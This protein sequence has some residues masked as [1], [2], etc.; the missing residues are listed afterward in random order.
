MI[1][2]FT[3]ILKEFHDT[4]TADEKKRIGQIMGFTEKETIILIRDLKNESFINS[5]DDV[6]LK[7]DAIRQIYDCQDSL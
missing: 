4:F 6:V 5:I 7:N 2:Q 1:K 3:Q